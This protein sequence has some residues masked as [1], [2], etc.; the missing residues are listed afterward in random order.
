MMKLALCVVEMTEIVTERGCEAT[1]RVYSPAGG[2]ATARLDQ[3][4][5]PLAARLEACLG[6]EGAALVSDDY[7]YDYAH[8]VYHHMRRT[9][10]AFPA[11]FTYD[12]MAA[13]LAVKLPLYQD[14][15]PAERARVDAEEDAREAHKA[16]M[17][18]A[19]G[20]WE[21]EAERRVALG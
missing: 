17:Y 11:L 12:D 18:D 7:D 4:P 3:L 5:R 8:P 16:A 19:D 14:M 20:T 13:V 10:T 1:V 21:I 9:V 2:T 15:T 6:S